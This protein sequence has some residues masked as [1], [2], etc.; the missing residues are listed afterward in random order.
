MPPPRTAPGCDAPVTQWDRSSLFRPRTPQNNNS[1]K[2]QQK[3]EELEVHMGLTG[4]LY[5]MPLLD[6][7]DI[8]R[9]GDFSRK[10]TSGELNES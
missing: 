6:F 2:H 1:N 7:G 9:R 10:T 5:V 3:S 4:L 8:A